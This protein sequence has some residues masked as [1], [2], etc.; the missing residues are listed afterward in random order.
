MRTFVVLLAICASASPA[1][2]LDRV[3]VVVNQHVIKSSDIDRAVRL[4]DFLNN[5]RVANNA[6]EKKKAADRLIDQ[7]VI[8]T[9][10]ATGRYSRPPEK[11][12]EALLAQIRRERFGGSETRLKQALGQYGITE[13][14][15]RA[16]L[17]WQLTVLRFINER[18]RPGVLISDDEIRNYYEQHRSSFRG[19]LESAS[20]AIRTSL[21]GEQINQQFETW[22]QGARGRAT[23]EYKQEAFL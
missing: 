5:E 9:E 12:A 6:A 11:D 21:E 1:V 22:L 18:F 20:S 16:Q 3:A 17:L 19:T 2:V 7:E 13:D 15:L 10:V 14:E 4:T 8:R 23:I